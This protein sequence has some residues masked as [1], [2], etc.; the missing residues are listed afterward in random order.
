MDDTEF[1][2][3]IIRPN[4]ELDPEL[5]ALEVVDPREMVVGD[6]YEIL[7]K[8]SHYDVIVPF[9]TLELLRTECPDTP[10]LE[11]CRMVF[12]ELKTDGKFEIIYNFHTHK[13]TC[14]YLTRFKK[15]GSTT[16]EIRLFKSP[17]DYEP[18]MMKGGRRRKTKRTR[19]VRHR[20]TK[21]RRHR[22]RRI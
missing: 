10:G 17:L 12:N 18:G 15:R 3:F 4:Q 13:F 16:D 20:K 7:G 11:V 1:L 19:R 9:T 5:A 2:G 8:Y 22:R 21:S 6:K 14:T